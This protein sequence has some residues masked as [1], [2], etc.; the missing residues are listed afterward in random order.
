MSVNH[1]TGIPY[2]PQGQEIVEYTHGALKTT[3][4]NKKGG[5]KF[6]VTT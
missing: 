3:T 6:L 4:K 2:N 5:V 1:K